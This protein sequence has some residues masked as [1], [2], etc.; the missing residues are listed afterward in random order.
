MA[1]RKG[2]SVERYYASKKKRQKRKRVRIYSVLILISI[3]VFITLSLT[4]F[5]NITS[6][7]VSGNKTYSTEQIITAAGLSEG[8][9]LFRLNKFK[10][11]E[12]LLVDLPYLQEV[13]ISRRL[14][15]TLCI[16]VKETTATFTAYKDGKYVL[17]SD[18]LKILGS[19]DKVPK[20]VAFIVGDTVKE[21][22][23]GYEAV[24]ENGS[25][26]IIKNIVAQTKDE[27]WTKQ[28]GAVDVSQ[29]YNLRVYYQNNR[30]KILLGNSDKL[31][32]KLQMACEA[33]KKNSSSEYARI[34]ITDGKAAY[35]RVL[36][37]DEIDDITA[38]LLGKAKAK[39]D[40]FYKSSD[41]ETLNEDETTT[42]EEPAA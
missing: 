17:L 8:D 20:G 15:T 27:F 26:E 2:N 1:D 6:F 12:K 10:M 31:G 32:D 30:V 28:I 11:I 7:E 40:K 16:E 23:S 13:T 41:E 25:E 5:F 9:N 4:V 3:A 36:A 19:A 22:A 35:Y 29:R 42:E 34:D 24:F 37:E 39:T 38:M 14:P 21:I 33:I 18:Q